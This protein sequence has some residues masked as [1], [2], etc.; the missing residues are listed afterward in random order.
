MQRLASPKSAMTTEL[1]S[2][3]RLSSRLSSFKSRCMTIWLCKYATP[4]SAHRTTTCAS[5]SARR[6]SRILSTAASTV[7]PYAISV[8]TYTRR[9]DSARKYS[10]MARIAGWCKVLMTLISFT[11]SSTDMQTSPFL[12]LPRVPPAAASPCSSSLP[13]SATPSPKE[14]WTTFIAYS[15]LT[16]TSSNSACT[17]LPHS[18]MRDTTANPPVPSFS[19]TSYLSSGCV[20]V[21]RRP[22]EV[23][24]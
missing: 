2:S 24:T 13:L 8:I 23:R 22:S 18:L 11:T 21:S 14:A 20:R 12:L 17:A 6:S 3:S 9:S 19:N 15:F 5:C 16:S 10:L 1:R 7:P 4:S